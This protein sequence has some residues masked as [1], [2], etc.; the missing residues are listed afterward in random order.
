MALNINPVNWFEIP[1]ND[2]GRARKFYESIFGIELPLR[3]PY[4]EVADV[5]T[6]LVGAPME[7]AW[8]P[9]ERNVPG[10]AGTL[11]KSKGYTPSHQGTMIY[12][13]VDDINEVLRK[14][15]QSG[16]KSLAPKTSIGEYGFIGLFED[17][18]G[19]RIGLHSMK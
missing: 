2:L 12:F 4:M 5:G 7:M 15:D 14:V 19:N 8:F 10:A 9:M 11:M 3:H 6:S 16:G 18:E 13:S 17:S 1:V